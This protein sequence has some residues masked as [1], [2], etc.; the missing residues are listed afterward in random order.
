MKQVIVARRDLGMG[1][2]KVAAQVAHA[3]LDAYEKADDDAAREW[4]SGGQ[5]KIVVRA[6]DEETLLELTEQARRAGLV[7]ALVRDAGRTQLDP[8]TVTALAIGPGR[9]ADIDPITGD[10]PLF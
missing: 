4:K 10:L 2:G 7:H 3:S 9:E 1:T 8:G 6:D 5:P